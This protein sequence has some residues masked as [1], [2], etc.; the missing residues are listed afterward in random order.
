MI[1]GRVQGIA[2]EFN[3][4]TV[5]SLGARLRTK[6]PE[7]YY[8]AF[9]GEVDEIVDINE[10]EGGVQPVDEVLKVVDLVDDDDDAMSDDN[11]NEV[12]DSPGSQ[13]LAEPPL[14]LPDVPEKLLRRFRATLGALKR[15]SKVRKNY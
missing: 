7:V 15:K 1:V 5:R 4:R 10:G 2:H 14:V 6:H 11:N 3:G 12:P 9:T 8:A 13:V